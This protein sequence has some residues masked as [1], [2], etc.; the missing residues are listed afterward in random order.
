MKNS[1]S[2][3]LCPV[4]GSSGACIH[5]C[6]SDG[7]PCSSRIKGVGIGVCIKRFRD[8]VRVCSRF[9]DVSSF[10]AWMQEV[11]KRGVKA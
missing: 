8:K 6:L 3:S 1:N 4:C 9:S 5:V 10:L 7:L 11:P 2:N